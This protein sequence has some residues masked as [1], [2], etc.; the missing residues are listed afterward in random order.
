MRTKTRN[1][2][3]RSVNGA[4]RTLFWYLKDS[5]CIPTTIDLSVKLNE[6]Y[7]ATESSLFSYYNGRHKVLIVGGEIDGIVCKLL[8]SVPFELLPR[9]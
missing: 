5:K 2:Y 4:E 3:A 1:P 6:S 8:F 9:Y 7:K